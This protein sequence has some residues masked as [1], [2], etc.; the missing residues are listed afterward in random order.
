MQFAA[1]GTSLYLSPVHTTNTGAIKSPCESPEQPESSSSGFTGSPE[2]RE[3]RNVLHR[4]APDTI[5]LSE[6]NDLTALPEFV[7]RTSFGNSFLG[8]TPSGNSLQRDTSSPWMQRDDVVG[9]SLQRDASPWD[10]IMGVV[11]NFNN[12]CAPI[13]FNDKKTESVHEIVHE[14]VITSDRLI[15]VC[16][17]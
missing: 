15:E 8:H 7:L 1:D 5:P 12:F 14:I 2:L 3:E 13:S 16:L 17:A 9:N 10:G 4:K 6:G 11:N